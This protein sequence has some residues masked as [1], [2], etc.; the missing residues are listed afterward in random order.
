MPIDRRPVW[1]QPHILGVAHTY[2]PREP[3]RAAEWPPVEMH[4]NDAPQ[5]KPGGELQLAG[6][7]PVYASAYPVYA[8]APVAF[9]SGPAWFAAP[10]VQLAPA[11]H[12]GPFGTVAA[13]LYGG[14]GH[15]LAPYSGTLGLYGGHAWSPG[16]HYAAPQTP[17]AYQYGHL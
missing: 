2:L 16:T 17:F 5:R 3:P 4:N 1:Q 11:A 14:M 7:P 15:A 13:Q 9:G 8:A 12:F 6:G 10:Q